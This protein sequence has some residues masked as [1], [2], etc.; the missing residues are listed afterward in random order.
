MQP[1]SGRAVKKPIEPGQ[2]GRSVPGSARQDDDRKIAECVRQHTF[3]PVLTYFLLGIN[4]RLFR[5]SARR[6]SGIGHARRN[7]RRAPI[8][9][10]PQR[11]QVL[12]HAQFRAR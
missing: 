5:F 6:G 11:L 3:G 10:R 7:L 2:Q 9:K 1:P 12:L 8:R 4:R